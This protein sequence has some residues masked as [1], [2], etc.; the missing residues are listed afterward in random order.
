MVK[1]KTDA[2][3]DFGLIVGYTGTASSFSYDYMTAAVTD[4]RGGA[5]WRGYEFHA[6]G[7]IIVGAVDGALTVTVIDGG[8]RTSADPMTV[9]GSALITLVGSVS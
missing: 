3:T 7:T 4:V 5:V 8:G 9:T 1:G 6:F 2:Q